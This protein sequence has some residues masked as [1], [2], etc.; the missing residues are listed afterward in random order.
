MKCR[1]YIGARYSDFLCF[2]TTEVGFVH[3]FGKIGQIFDTAPVDHFD[4]L[5][6]AIDYIEM[7]HGDGGAVAR[8]E[9]PN[10]GQILS[11]RPK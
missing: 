7:A 8:E 2:I 3:S 11:H 10:L 4:N 5:Q 9:M 6:N 1:R